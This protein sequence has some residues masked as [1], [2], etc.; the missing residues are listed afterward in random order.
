MS[1]H[2]EKDS[3]Q[4]WG[5]FETESKIFG[6]PSGL[7]LKEL[8]DFFGGDIDLYASYFSIGMFKSRL[9]PQLILDSARKMLTQNHCHSIGT[10]WEWAIGDDTAKAS[11][12]QIVLAQPRLLKAV[13]NFPMNTKN[14]E[15]L[16]KLYG[17]TA[18]AQFLN[19]SPEEGRAWLEDSLGL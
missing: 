18:V 11:V 3:S 17:A 16:I 19:P 7:S 1:H 2:H 13:V 10:L 9:P 15:M 6:N 4:D 14:R 5:D 12:A 8:L